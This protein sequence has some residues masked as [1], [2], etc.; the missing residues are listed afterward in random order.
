VLAQN[1][2]DAFLVGSANEAVHPG[3]LHRAMMRSRNF[4]INS[5]TERFR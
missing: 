3:V 2:E 5:P 4:S 1:P